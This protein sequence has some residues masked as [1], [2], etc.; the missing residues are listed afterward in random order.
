M[1]NVAVSMELLDRVTKEKKKELRCLQ[2]DWDFRAELLSKGVFVGKVKN[3][4]DKSNHSKAPV[5]PNKKERKTSNVLTTFFPTCQ[6]RVVR[7]YQSC[8]F[9]LLLLLLFL[10][11]YQQWTAPDLNQT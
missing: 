11:K 9:L 4:S 10:L 6:V 7:F 2:K 1:K 8:P 3:Q 5:G